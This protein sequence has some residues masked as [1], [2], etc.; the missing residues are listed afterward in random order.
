[1]TVEVDTHRGPFD[2]AGQTWVVQVEVV[3]VEVVLGD[4][5]R[6]FDQT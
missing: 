1:M 6:H 5:G 3:Q 4:F 2:S